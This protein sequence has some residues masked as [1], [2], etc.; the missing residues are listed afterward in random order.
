MVEPLKR[1]C[2]PV[3][4]QQEGFDV[5]PHVTSTS[6]GVFASVPTPEDKFGNVPPGTLTSDTTTREEQCAWCVANKGSMNV[7]CH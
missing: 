7:W 6:S 4:T 3:P 1:L 5:I 2:C